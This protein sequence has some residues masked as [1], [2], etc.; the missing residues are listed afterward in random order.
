M[1]TQHPSLIAGYI[2]G[3][4]LYTSNPG[5]PI[6]SPADRR[7]SGELFGRAERL[8][9]E[10]AT[11]ACERQAH[12][13]AQTPALERAALLKQAGELVLAQSESLIA[14]LATEAGK[15]RQEALGEV[16]A[17][18]GFLYGFAAW[19]S[20]GQHGTVKQNGELTVVQQKYPRGTAAIITPWNYPLSN[21]C[22]KIAA[23]LI[24][25]NPVIWRPSV[26]TPSLSVKL[27]EILHQAGLPAGVFN[28]LLED[29]DTVSKALVAH[30][31]VQAVSFTGSTRVGL[32]VSTAA[33]ARGAAI[34]CE[35]GGK[36]AA[37]VMP[38][39]DLDLAAARIAFGAFSF[40][41]QKCTAV[42][43]LLVHHEVAPALIEKLIMQMRTYLP[44]D[45]HA[46]QDCLAP[47]I[48]S[49]QLTKL[50]QVIDTARR[51]GLQPLTGGHSI[52]Q[53]TYQHGNYFAP[54]LM[55][56]ET[57]KDPLWQ[58][59]CFGPI[60]SLRRFHNLDAAIGEVNDSQY[61]LGAAIFSQNLS[62]I[63]QFCRNVQTGVIKVNDVPPG[64]YPHISAGGW[65]QSG[66]GTNELSEDGVDFFMHKK[67]VYL[68]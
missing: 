1:T 25:G 54:T 22:Q 8:H 12:T 14:L 65:K 41:G 64:L 50:T 13:W 5:F 48:S 60:L 39:A 4:W 44:G 47:L 34:Q 63:Q 49:A 59:E 33:A 24:G 36:N 53:G 37:V 43:R 38:D 29:K 66:A 6:P 55:E 17:A 7:Q 67:S 23:A 28:L 18:A 58:E 3:Q 26:L 68:N 21:P 42:S 57:A 30:P 11:A 46:Q 61:G 32:L 31:S 27:T 35:M 62:T 9:L 45:K 16:Q 52:Q 10:Q 19:A 51:R 15:P 40:A 2:D 20:W 56:L